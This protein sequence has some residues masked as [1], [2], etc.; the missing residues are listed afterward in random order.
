[1]PILDWPENVAA[2]LLRGDINRIEATQ[3]S[4][5]T[6]DRLGIKER[7]AAKIREEIISNHVRSHDSQ[8]AMREKVR[9]AL[10]ELTIVTGEKMTE[11]VERVD[12][13]LDVDPADRRHLFYE[14]MKDCFFALRDI[15]PDEIDDATIDLL[16]QQADEL[17]AIV[18]SIKRR[19]K[20]KE[21][22][23]TGW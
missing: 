23:I 2:A 22:R 10:G 6:A 12:A 16:T 19:R 4:R 1:M 17:M 20:Q 3:V 14:V 13:L 15:S 11:A 5:L 9:E 7:E 18:H 21:K 8:P